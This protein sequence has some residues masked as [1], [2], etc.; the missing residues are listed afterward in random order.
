MRMAKT[1]VVLSADHAGYCIK[2]AVKPVLDKLKI[3]YKDMGAYNTDSVDYPLY[4]LKA[5]QEI[6]SKRAKRG[7]MVCG[8]GIGLSIA[9]NKVPGIRAALCDSPKIAEL[10]R[11]HNDSNVLILAGRFISTALAKK[12][13]HKWLTTD[14]SG[15][16]RHRR[17]IKQISGIEN[18]FRKNRER[19]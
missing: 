12:I 18:K 1:D 13:V 16:S 3:K 15:E 7:I 10:S 5:A 6:I 2:E 14:F 17:R 4:A 19:I 8:S 9:A 11:T